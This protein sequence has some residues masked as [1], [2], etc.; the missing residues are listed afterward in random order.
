MKGTRA[1]I[2]C[3]R[4]LD[5]RSG[6]N[7][8][9]PSS[10]GLYGNSSSVSSIDASNPWKIEEV[11]AVFRQSKVLLVLATEAHS[12]TLDTKF[13]H[14]VSRTS[15]VCSIG[16]AADPDSKILFIYPLD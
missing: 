10:V 13:V 9:G 14:T 2:P 5:G 6:K 16:V 3:S 7:P 1:N 12:G 8:P 4:S 15:A 11:F